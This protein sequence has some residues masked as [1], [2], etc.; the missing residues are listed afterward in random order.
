VSS[1]DMPRVAII[2]LNWNGWKDTIQCL[3]SI[4]NNKYNNYKIFICDNGSKDGSLKKIREWISGKL[5]DQILDQLNVSQKR[6]NTYCL[7]YAYGDIKNDEIVLSGNYPHLVMIDIADNLGFSG[8]NNVGIRLALKD[9]KIEYFWLLNNDTLISPDSLTQLVNKSQQFSNTALLSSYIT[10]IESEKKVW[11][12]GGIYDPWTATSKHVTTEK[13]ASHKYQY[14]SGCS[15]F[16]SRIVLQTIGLLDESIFLYAEDIDYSVRAKN[17]QIKLMIVRE[18]IVAHK[19][20]ASSGIGSPRAYKLHVMNIIKVICRHYGNWY[21]L[22]IIPYHLVKI[23]YLVLIK[24]ISLRSMQAY[25]AGLYL[26][27]KEVI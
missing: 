18:S 14:L 3:D 9:S 22:T 7:E 25:C 1:F 26:G 20:G 2:I 10:T 19:G 5:S 12:E 21:L 16:I 23:C 17:K 8:G 24:R 27:I 13:F 4:I 6:S 15:L 11:F